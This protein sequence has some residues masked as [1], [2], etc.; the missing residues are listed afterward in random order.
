MLNKDPHIEGAVQSLADILRRM[1]RH[2][3]KK[4]PLLKP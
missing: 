2:Q 4:F 1:A 3:R